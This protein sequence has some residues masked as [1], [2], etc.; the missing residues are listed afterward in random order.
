MNYCNFRYL[1]LSGS[2]GGGVLVSPL[3]LTLAARVPGTG[4]L[5]WDGDYLALSSDHGLLMVHFTLGL[6]EKPS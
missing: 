5:R 4:F 6:E 2:R 3:S 1:A